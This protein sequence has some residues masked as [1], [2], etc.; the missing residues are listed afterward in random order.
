MKRYWLLILAILLLRASPTRAQEATPVITDDQVNAIAKELYCPVCEN[1][2][3]DVCPTQACADW[4]EEIRLKLSQGQTEQQIIQYFVDRYGD[5]VLGAPPARGLSWLV[6][7]LPPV[8]IL[9]GVFVLFRAFRAW[10]QAAPQPAAEAL[11]SQP[12]DDEYVKR[13]EEELK[14]SDR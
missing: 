14:K 9:A 2:S 10:K 1:I 13:L 12:P 8:M 4:R 7:I 5:Q 11:P 3:L 6:Y